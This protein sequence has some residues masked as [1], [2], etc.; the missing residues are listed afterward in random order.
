MK[1][2]AALLSL[3]AVAQTQ[4]APSNERPLDAAIEDLE[5]QGRN[6]QRLRWENDLLLF[7]LS[8]P[9][10]LDVYAKR[11]P[12]LIGRK[13]FTGSK[14]EDRK[15][16]HPNLVQLT[17]QGDTCGAAAW[18]ISLNTSDR[19]SPIRPWT[20]NSFTDDSSKPHYGAHCGFNAYTHLPDRLICEG[21]WGRIPAGST[22]VRGTLSFDTRPGD[23]FVRMKLGAP[24][25]L[26][27][28]ND[29][30]WQKR[31]EIRI[32]LGMAVL[33][34]E[35][36]V[37]RGAN[38]LTVYAEPSDGAARSVGLAV[39]Y[40]RADGAAELARTA[41]GRNRVL[42][43]AYKLERYFN[44]PLWLAVGWDGDGSCTSADQ[45]QRYVETL[46][47]RFEAERR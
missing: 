8:G 29:P 10:V 3:L 23:H 27:T 38:Y 4:T 34:G 40:Q 17:P 12:G 44:V 6:I 46:A 33:D 43:F 20:Y 13:I 14:D 11:Q 1:T 22:H 35:K 25:W 28:R 42:Y 9:A 47:E 31:D 39:I 18:L 15:A 19:E 36:D 37:R 26:F 45:W 32:G 30:E 21:I 41:D 5:V 2:F 24:G 16:K 7:S